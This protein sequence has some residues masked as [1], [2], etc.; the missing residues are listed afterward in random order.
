MEMISHLIYILAS[1]SGMDLSLYAVG[2]VT[3]PT[4]PTCQY[5]R[6]HVPKALT[7]AHVTSPG[8]T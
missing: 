4:M 5:P 6:G 1:I 2:Y 3:T 8:L 7:P